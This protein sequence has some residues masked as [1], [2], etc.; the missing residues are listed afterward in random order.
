MA[1]TR[2]PRKVHHILPL[3]EPRAD[4]DA[5]PP[6]G[7]EV[8]QEVDFL[9]ELMDLNPKQKIL[10]MASG[11]GRHAL[12]LARR[13][14]PHV[15]ALDLSDQLLEIGRRCAK[16]LDL[17][18]EFLKGDARKAQVRDQFDAAFI[19]GGGAFG[20]M[21]SDQDNQAILDA[22]FASLKPGGRVAV[23]GRNLLFLLRHGEDLSGFDPQTHYFTTT[24]KVRVEG[25]T[26][27][28]F[29]VRERYYVYPGLKKD[30]EAAGFRNVVGFGAD[31]GRFSS[32]AVS[33]TDP[34]LLLYAI[35]P[36]S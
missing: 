21:E 36:R 19:L 34:E 33:A 9:I 16:T 23:S 18:V 5:S 28:E 12:E 14:F 8:V 3:P 22:A 4:L 13:D 17:S 15:T 27:E 24:D 1:L 25:D 2:P 26:V 11:A 20:L 10:D 29:P 30:V 7:R 32:R 6:F 35:K 31:A